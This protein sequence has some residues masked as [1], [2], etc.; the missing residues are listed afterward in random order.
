MDFSSNIS[1]YKLT[2]ERIKIEKIDNIVKQIQ[3]LLKFDQKCT[4]KIKSIMQKQIN[5]YYKEIKY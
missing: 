4:K 1:N 2:Y 3:K 5:N